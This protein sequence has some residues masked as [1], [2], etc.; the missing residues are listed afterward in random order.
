LPKTRFL[1]GHIQNIL[2]IFFVFYLILCSLAINNKCQGDIR[3]IWHLVI[4]NDGM[5]VKLPQQRKG[6]RVARVGPQPQPPFPGGNDATP[7]GDKTMRVYQPVRGAGARD[8]TTIARK[9]PRAKPAAWWMR[10]G[11]APDWFAVCMNL[12]RVEWI[13]RRKG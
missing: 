4:F 3:Y 6:A 12:L 7:G 9:G 11:G 10:S 1:Y 8:D 2:R 5:M 13:C